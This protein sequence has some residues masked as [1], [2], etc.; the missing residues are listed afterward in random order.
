MDPVE[1]FFNNKLWP[2]SPKGNMEKAYSQFRYAIFFDKADM[3]VILAK[4]IEYN[5]M[6]DKE[7]RESKYIKSLESF[8]KDKGW[9][10]EYKTKDSKTKRFIDRWLN[11]LKYFL[12]W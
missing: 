7:G 9:L 12:S 11:G 2:A 10:G 3:D 1:E 4:W 6:V 5:E 8:L